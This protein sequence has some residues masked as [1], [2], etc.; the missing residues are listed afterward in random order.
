MGGDD[1]SQFA[2]QRQDADVG[3][4]DT[5][6]APQGWHAIS[7]VFASHLASTHRPIT[8][9]LLGEER[10]A[11]NLKAK[12]DGLILPGCRTLIAQRMMERTIGALADS[13]ARDRRPGGVRF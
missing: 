10:P 7:I 8:G 4:R 11:A 5:T 9:N 12:A 13:G 2:D 6:E 3:N 1:A